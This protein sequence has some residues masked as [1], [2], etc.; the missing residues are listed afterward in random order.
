M[1]HCKTAN[2]KNMITKKNAIFLFVVTLIS[3]KT[4]CQ[5]PSPIGIIFNPRVNTFAIS[6]VGGGNLYE[7]TAEKS[8]T[9]GQLAI[10]W[11]IGLMDSQTK[12]K[13]KEKLTTLTSI[14][15]YN[16]FLQANFISGD[17]LELR[18]IAYVD[19]EF[20][21]FFGIRLT[22]LKTLGLDNNSKLVNMVFID[23][24]TADY[25]LKSTNTL[26]TGFRNIN[27]TLGYQIGYITNTDFGLVGVTFSPQINFLNIYENKSNG[28]S[29]EELNSSNDA[30]SR[31]VLG[32]GFKINAPL[33]DFCFF[34]EA[35]KY[36]PLDNSRQI[37]G[38]TD[39]MIFSFGGVAT[40]TVFKT[41]TKESKYND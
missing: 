36:F 7:L 16:P 27:L 10:D 38:L 34:F 18:K 26:N 13:G 9:S 24:S 19:N 23:F 20:Q 28:S 4:F 33:N 1:V 12:K 15:K 22:N 40:G 6:G 39:R 17:S 37:V 41:K 3:T 5:Q 21:F 32:G 31:N 8:S 14:I 29:F 25:Q 35:R 2:T 11:N 30:L